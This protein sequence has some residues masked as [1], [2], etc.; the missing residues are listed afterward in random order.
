MQILNTPN[1]LTSLGLY[2]DEIRVNKVSNTKLQ[3]H[4]DSWVELRVEGSTASQTK[5]SSAAR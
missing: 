4:N 5:Q 3:N 1:N 2:Y